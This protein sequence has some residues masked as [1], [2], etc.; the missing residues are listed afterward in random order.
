VCPITTA[1]LAVAFAHADDVADMINAQ[2][3]HQRFLSSITIALFVTGNAMCLDQT[4][5]SSDSC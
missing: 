4:F 5:G 1:R 3:V 2:L